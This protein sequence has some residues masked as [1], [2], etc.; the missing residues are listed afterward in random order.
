MFGKDLWFGLKGC[1]NLYVVITALK[2]EVE[3]LTCQ[4]A[5]VSIII[6]DEKLPDAIVITNEQL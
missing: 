4:V 5:G 3:W 1:W 6:T 2:K